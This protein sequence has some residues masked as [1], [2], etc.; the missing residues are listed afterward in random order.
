MK[1]TTKI[2]IA[3]VVLLAI[4]LLTGCRDTYRYP[5]Q[6]VEN[7]DKPECQRPLCE[8]HKQCPSHI[9]GRDPNFDEFVKH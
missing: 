8:V 1:L 9:F 6:N 5:C 4:G 2:F 7:W 3:G